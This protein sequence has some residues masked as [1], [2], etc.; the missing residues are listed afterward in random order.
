[1]GT[2]EVKGNDIYF[3]Y[4]GKYYVAKGEKTNF[5]KQKGAN[6]MVIKMSDGS[7]IIQNPSKNV[8]YQNGYDPVAADKKRLAETQKQ[9]TEKQTEQARQQQLED[10]RTAYLRSENL[11]KQ[12][13]ATAKSDMQA[14]KQQVDLQIAKDY[15]KEEMKKMEAEVQKL[16]AEIKNIK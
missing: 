15:A 9:E 11:N 1:M 10:E 4:N 8:A 7:Y 3:Q 13:I 16:L 5:Q 12:K 2:V 14:E 6:M